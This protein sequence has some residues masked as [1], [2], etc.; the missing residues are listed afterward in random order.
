MYSW[1]DGFEQWYKLIRNLYVAQWGRITV[2][3]II[4]KYAP[5]SDGNNEAQYIA[6]LKRE[7]DTWHA[8]I[9]RP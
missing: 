1:V 8:G 7:I 6:T 5:N 3:Q 2:D 4:P 9:L